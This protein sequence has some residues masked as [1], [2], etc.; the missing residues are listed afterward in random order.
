MNGKTNNMKLIASDLDGT[1]FINSTITK[2]DIDAIKAF[3]EKGNLFVIATGRSINHA[4]NELKKFKID[5]DYILGVNGAL[6]VND[7]LEVI[8]EKQM[9]ETTVSKIQKILSRHDVKHYH[10]SNG[11][12]FDIITTSETFDENLIT[13]KQIKGYYIETNSSDTALKLANE[14]KN[15]LSELGIKAYTNQHFVAIGMEGI[16]KGSGIAKLIELINFKGKVYTVGDDYNDIPMFT[17]FESYGI[18][19][20]F[21]GAIKFAKN[22]AK[23]VSEVINKIK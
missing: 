14:L 16:N 20:G 13:N 6:A 3:R 9:D 18:S 21:S 15:E 1:L 19:S 23:S 5:F 22:K 2:A 11:L 8:Y 7:K 17:K 12:D 10:L 4:A